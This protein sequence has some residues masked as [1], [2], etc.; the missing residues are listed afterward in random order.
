MTKILE[1]QDSIIKFLN[2]NK[3]D[4]Y[5]IQSYAVVPYRPKIE[6]KIQTIIWNFIF[7]GIHLCWHLPN[8]DWSAKTVFSYKFKRKKYVCNEKI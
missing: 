1:P 7:T 5:V 3:H 6:K 2:V 4:S 8:M